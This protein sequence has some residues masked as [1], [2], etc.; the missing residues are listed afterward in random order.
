M[1]RG[2]TPRKAVALSYPSGAEA[3]LVAAKGEGD[4]CG[5]ILR[6]A[7]EYGIPVHD[8]PMLAEALCRFPEGDPI[9]PDLYVAVAEVYAF[10]IRAHRYLVQEEK[11]AG[12]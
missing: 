7:G 2:E 3:P 10:L 11:I 12:R 4:L 5:T 6:L 9:P 8:D 1:N